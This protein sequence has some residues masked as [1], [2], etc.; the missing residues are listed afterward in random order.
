MDNI[1]QNMSYAYDVGYAI[2][3]FKA[4]LSRLQDIAGKSE[5][6]QNKLTYL[7]QD[8]RKTIQYLETRHK[9]RNEK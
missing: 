3:T 4:D 9:Q 2:G 5:E 8:C 6:D 7:I 1:E